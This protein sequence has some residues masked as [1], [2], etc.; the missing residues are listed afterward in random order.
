MGQISLF[1]TLGGAVG[2]GDGGFDMEFTI[3]SISLLTHLVTNDKHHVDIVTRIK[4]K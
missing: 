4:T 2:G 1:H 3:Y